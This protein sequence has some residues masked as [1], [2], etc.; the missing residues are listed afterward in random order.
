MNALQLLLVTGLL[1]AAL[2]WVEKITRPPIDKEIIVR[3]T[4]NVQR[5]TEQLQR[6]A[7]ASRNAALAIEAFKALIATLPRETEE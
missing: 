7:T 3:L 2:L 6:M 4:L 1:I 5:F